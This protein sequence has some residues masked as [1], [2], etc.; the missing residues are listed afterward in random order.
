VFVFVCLVQFFCADDFLFVLCIC[1]CNLHMHTNAS[2]HSCTKINVDV[3][4]TFQKFQN[5]Q[6]RAYKHFD[7]QINHKSNR[8][9]ILKSALRRPSFPIIASSY[10]R[11]LKDQ[12]K[13]AWNAPDESLRYFLGIRKSLQ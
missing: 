1:F 5:P 4:S 3:C 9:D 2:S 7:P 10:F 8:I 13:A 12:E 6:R 11:R